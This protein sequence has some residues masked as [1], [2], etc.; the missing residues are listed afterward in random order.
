[1]E[2]SEVV[3]HLAGRGRK[4]TRKFYKRIDEGFLSQYSSRG[5]SVNLSLRHEQNPGP[6]KTGSFL[7]QKG[8]GNNE[9]RAAVAGWA[10]HEATMKGLRQISTTVR[11]PRGGAEK[12]KKSNAL[13]KSFIYGGEG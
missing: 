8:N 4:G 10:K 11:P 13:L 5:V 2:R 7:D 9:K 12:T 6:E 1:M 3:S